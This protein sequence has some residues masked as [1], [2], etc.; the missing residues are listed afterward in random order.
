LHRAR[1]A[2]RIGGLEA[3]PEAIDALELIFGGPLPW[4]ADFF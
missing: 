3:T 4:I 1:D 2:V